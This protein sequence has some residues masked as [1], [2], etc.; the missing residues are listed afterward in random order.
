MCGTCKVRGRVFV[1]R[2]VSAR[3]C[4]GGEAR[5]ITPHASRVVKLRSAGESPPLSPLTCTH[6]RI[7]LPSTRVWTCCS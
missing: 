4:G 3:V 6:T 5:L 7:D 2:E 1:V